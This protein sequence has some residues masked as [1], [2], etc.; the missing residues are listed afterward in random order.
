MRVR[1]IALL[2]AASLWLAVG[3]GCA[4]AGG[5]TKAPDDPP[6]ITGTIKRVEQSAAQGT[7]L[8]MLVEGGTQP[9]GAVS[10]K[11][12][13]SVAEDTP[14]VSAGEAVPLSELKQGASV[15]VWFDGPVA[16]SYPVQGTASFVE[17]Q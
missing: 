4:G 13:V 7:A 16:E 3:V 10:D 14:V 9:A 1:R 5:S 6:G 17:V 8:T 15:K 11:A 12:M 2:A